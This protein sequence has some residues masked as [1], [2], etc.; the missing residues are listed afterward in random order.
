MGKCVYTPQVP[1]RCPNRAE[2]RRPPLLPLN[3]QPFDLVSLECKEN[4][5]AFTAESS[6]APTTSS[7]LPCLHIHPV[8]SLTPWKTWEATFASDSHLYIRLQ[9]GTWPCCKELVN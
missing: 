6:N 4:V 3:F 1:E 8:H 2:T 7:A 9:D 5:G